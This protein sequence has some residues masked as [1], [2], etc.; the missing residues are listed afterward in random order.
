M[1][2]GLLGII[3][4]ESIIQPMDTTLSIATLQDGS[5]LLM[6]P[7]HLVQ[8]L[9]DTIIPQMGLLLFRGTLLETPTL[10]IDIS[11]FTSIL[12]VPI[13]PPLVPM[14]PTR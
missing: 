8:T 10:L 11:P 12:L 2:H 5:I 9:H 14:L 3:P 13:I 4:H 6:V 1:G 7:V